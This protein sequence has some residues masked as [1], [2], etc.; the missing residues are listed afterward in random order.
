MNLVDRVKNIL[1]SP[2]TEWPKIA[3]ET[4][5][6]QSTAGAARWDPRWVMGPLWPSSPAAWGSS[7]RL[8]AT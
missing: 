4:A 6:T 3:E 5:T 7:L 8:W 1:V 2:Q